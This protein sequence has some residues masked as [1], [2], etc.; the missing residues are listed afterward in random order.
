[1]RSA[2]GATATVNFFT[3]AFN[4]IVIV[5][6][7]RVLHVRPAVL[8]LVLGSGAIGGLLGSFVTGRV[9]RRIGL[10]PTFITGCVLLPT[11]QFWHYFEG[12][13]TPRCWWSGS[14]ERCEPVTTI[15]LEATYELPRSIKVRGDVFGRERPIKLAGLD[16]VLLLPNLRS[17]RDSAVV[18]APLVAGS[19]RGQN[20]DMGSGRNVPLVGCA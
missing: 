16:G 13:L 8:G 4:A 20:A 10:G 5:Y 17:G 19:D 14:V 9:T 2:L 15:E 6:A 3:L 18:V 7:T 11:V 12:P 1:V